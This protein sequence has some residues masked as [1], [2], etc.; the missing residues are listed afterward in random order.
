MGWIIFWLWFQASQ[1]NIPGVV[2]FVCVR[3]PKIF[4]QLF[5]IGC[6]TLLFLLLEVSFLVEVLCFLNG[7]EPQKTQWLVHLCRTIST[8]SAITT[9]FA[10]C[11]GSSS[12]ISSMCRKQRHETD[13]PSHQNTKQKQA[14]HV[15]RTWAA[16]R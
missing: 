1:Y 5:G 3:P 8:M 4:L 6:F 16:D 2:H 13:H 15:L 12:T 9:L 7:W 10:A 14:F 11:V